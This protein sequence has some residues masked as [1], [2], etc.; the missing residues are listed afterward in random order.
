MHLV[1]LMDGNY[2]RK[3]DPTDVTEEEWAFVAP[4]LSLM[5]PDAPQRVHEVREV[6]KALHGIVRAGSCWR[7]L[8]TNFPRGRF[9]HGAAGGA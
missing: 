5:S 2:L 4:Y 9:G 7:L 3:P 1:G 6:F 8:P